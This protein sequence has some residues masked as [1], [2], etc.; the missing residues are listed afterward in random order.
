MKFHKVINS[1]TPVVVL[2]ITVRSSRHPP[3]GI[4]KA[5]CNG[6]YI[7]LGGGNL[8]LFPALPLVNF[9]GQIT[10]LIISI[11][12]FNLKLVTISVI[13]KLRASNIS[14]PGECITN[15]A[16][17]VCP[18]LMESETVG[19]GFTNISFNKPAR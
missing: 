7:D 11:I 6:G 15:A 12:I 17:Q 18:V 2:R 8:V 10:F 4:P 1:F 5:V 19:A 9:V 13:L 16:S 3:Q 14:S